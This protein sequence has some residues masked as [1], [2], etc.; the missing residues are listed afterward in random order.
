[1][2]F[3]CS[4]VMF[5]SLVWAQVVSLGD[6]PDFYKGELRYDNSHAV[7]I[8]VSKYNHFQKLQGPNV[9]TRAI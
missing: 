4:I 5:S 9:D 1:M 8:G 7:I 6:S 3:I 2:K